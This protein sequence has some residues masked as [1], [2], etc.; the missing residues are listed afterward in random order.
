MTKGKPLIPHK[1]LRDG[2]IVCGVCQTQLANKESF[3]S[4][5]NKLHP[6]YC[7]SFHQKTKVNL[8]KERKQHAM[9]QRLY[10][11]RQTDQVVEEGP[12][13]DLYLHTCGSFN[14]GSARGQRA[15]SIQEQVVLLTRQLW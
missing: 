2:K 6:E 9:S 10:R 8:K 11:L 14:N 5:K 1:T 3:A 7:A 15:E 12:P 13:P 4:H